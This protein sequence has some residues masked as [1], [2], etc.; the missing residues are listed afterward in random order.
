VDLLAAAGDAFDPKK[1]EAGD[2]SPM[3]FGSAMNNFGLEA[4]LESFCEL[5]PPPVGRATSAGFVASSDPRFTAYVFKMQANMD[6]AHR[7]RVAFIRI[8]SGSFQRGMKVRHVRTGRDLRLSNPTQF[9]AQERSIVEEAFAGDV[10]GVY[11]PG[12]FEIGDT[13]TDGADLAFEG[14]PSFAPEHFARLTMVDP[15]RRKQ[16][17][18]GIEQLA[19][20]GTIQLYRPPAGR[21]G[22]VV[23]GAVGPLQLE[24]VKY[25]LKVEYDV[26]VRLESIPYN[27]ARWVTRKEGGDVDMD[28]LRRAEVG[29]AV[30][31]VR[32]RP[33]L[34]FQSEWHMGSAPKYL[35]EDYVLGET[36]HGVVVRE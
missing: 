10:I 34:L 16:L 17:A 15:L 18:K 14:I 1:F 27:Y 6:R 19:Q 31:D 13:L 33:V 24:V 5:M 22:D 3:F 35:P 28:I 11:D 32:E 8:C 21:A 26:E 7:D 12:V 30:V 4:F 9:I 29:I 20:E 36:A 25:R 2:V 23:L